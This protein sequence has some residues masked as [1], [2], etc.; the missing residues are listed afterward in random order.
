M[1]SFFLTVNSW[2]TSGSYIAMLGAFVW[3][4]VS[5]ALSPC[6]MASIPLMVTYVAGQDQ[7]VK[8]KKAASYAPLPSPADS[9]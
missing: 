3:G 8:P 9:S 4:M 6:H 7:A 5:V 1:D 2:I